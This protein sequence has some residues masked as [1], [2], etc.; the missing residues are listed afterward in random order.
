MKEMTILACRALGL[1]LLWMCSTFAAE[2]QS[3]EEFQLPVA[4]GEAVFP[5][6]SVSSVSAS[7][8]S[9]PLARTFLPEDSAVVNWECNHLVFPA[10]RQCF[11]S[12]FH[13]VGQLSADPYA[14]LRVLHIGGSHVQADIFSGRLRSNLQRL[15]P[16]HLVNRGLTFPYSVMG[17]NG[18]RDYSYQATG[19]WSKSRNIESSPD[20]V[21]GLS[22]AAI[23]T[24][25]VSS[26]LTFRS[27]RPF[28]SVLLY[29]QNLS[30][31]AWVYPVLIA[32]RD[33]IPAPHVSGQ[34]G[35]EFLFSEPV[36]E[37]T[38]ALA[39]DS[40]GGFVFR[41]LVADPYSDGLTYTSSG[42][43][44]AAVPSWLRC[45]AF[46]AE[47][48]PVA[49]DLVLLAI[50]INDANVKE[51]SAEQFKQNYRTLLRRILRC[52]PQC[53]FLFITNNDCYLNTGRRRRS[54]NKN[55]ALVEQAFMDLAAEFNGAVWNLY[56]V[57]GGFE[58][59]GR[60]VKAGY[61]QSDHVHFTSRG[62]EL[63][64]DLL[65]NAF[66]EAMP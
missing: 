50:G 61:M 60:W 16:Q 21:L 12:L 49:P 32:G 51:F 54:Y 45:A 10:G 46:E 63:L 17:T 56:Q 2:A 52:N 47:L 31:T 28:E 3:E 41:G 19:T 34:E 55:T 26:T 48:Q 62:Y 57:M 27:P 42:I 6:I 23:A 64:G 4:V 38:L 40:C 30:D 11:D 9:S 66:L 5:G 8:P 18:P 24:T 43:N 7:S 53:A 59:S 1:M 36:T 13:H 37:C 44:G 39:G 25:D 58:S 29:G 20:Y 14:R 15:S 22:G 35:F 33:T 65:F